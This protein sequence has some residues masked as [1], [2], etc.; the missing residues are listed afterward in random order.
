[1]WC[2]S[3]YEYVVGEAT[4]VFAVYLQTSGFQVSRRKSAAVDS[5]VDMVS[6]C[7]TPLLMLLLLL[8]FVMLMYQYN[9]AK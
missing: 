3:A 8:S 7:R 1:M 6:P 2:I 4:K 9:D 5:L